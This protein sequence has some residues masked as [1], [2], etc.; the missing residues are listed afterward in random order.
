M[1]KRTLRVIVQPTHRTY[2]VCIACGR[3]QT[4]LEVVIT[5]DLE[6]QAGL[7][8]KCL[9]LVHHKRAGK[10]AAPAA[11]VSPALSDEDVA[12]GIGRHEGEM[13]E[14]IES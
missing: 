2:L 1:A 8:K 6:P 10:R 12:E 7:H 11:T 13:A 9:E 3:F 4:E 5:G 14:E